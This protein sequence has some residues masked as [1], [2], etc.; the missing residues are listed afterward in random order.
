MKKNTD[1]IKRRIDE[2]RNT[3]LEHNH[4]YYVKNEPVISDFEYDILLQDLA[5]LE[6]KYPQFATIDSPTVKVGSDIDKKTGGS[7][8]E[9]SAH[10]FPMLSLSNTYDKGELDAF[11]ERVDKVNNSYKVSCELKIDGTA[12][13]L[14]YTEG[15]L[16]RALT[17]GDGI[18]G[19]DV[20]EN[21]KLIPSIPQKLSGS[22]YPKDFDIR[23]EIFMPYSSFDRLNQERAESGENLFANPRNAASGSLKLQDSTLIINRGLD[24]IL[25]HIVCEDFSFSSHYESLQKAAEWGLPTSKYTE[26]C[27]SRQDVFDYIDKWDVA[28]RNLPYATD[29]VVIKIDDIALQNSLG[30]TAK[31]PRWATAYKFKPEE[32]LTKLISVDFQVGRTGAVTPVANL[33]PVHLSG[34]KVKRA[35]LHNADQI[36]LLDIHFNDYVFVEKGG[37]IIPKITGVDKTK[38]NEES[39]KVL[40]PEFCPDCG[41]KLQRSELEARHYCPNSIGCPTQ[42]K[43]KIVH[44]CGRKAMDILAG[45]A[46]I[47]QFFQAGFIKNPADLYELD[48]ERLLTLEGWKDRSAERFLESLKSSRAVP[49]NRVLFALGIRHIG[50]TTAKNLTTGLN[51]IS[52]I[53]NATKEELLSIPE[54]GETLADSII[55]YF[56]DSKNIELID[57]LKS[58]GLNFQ[59]ESSKSEV[60]SDKLKGKTIVISGNFSISREAIGALIESHSGRNSSS[61]SSKTDYLLAGEKAGPSKLEK[62]AK[63]G[64]AI[65]TEE[66][67][68]NM[69]NN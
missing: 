55:E 33:E 66:E 25:Y 18:V 26:L 3:I 23:G 22:G 68:M 14:T 37:E 5:G 47:E 21:V 9:Q 57:R 31:S 41:T 62:A 63:L 43:A 30:Y 34:T 12:I 40:F 38:R 29:G 15:V 4:R 39:A 8:F 60:I 10:R 28:R 6:K 46:T 13:S 64:V 58:F 42:I 52:K 20:T 56:T 49:F 48:K 1:D 19:D 35:S 2:L 11:F 50:E 16:K 24:C 7:F 44:F 51:E 32:A 61:V 67:F 17:R 54:V 36:E 65:I 69:I 27:E 59:S 53:A 45:D